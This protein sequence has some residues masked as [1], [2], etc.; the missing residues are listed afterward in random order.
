MIEDSSANKK[1]RAQI[2][3]LIDGRVILVLVTAF[4][5][6]IIPIIT[7]LLPD[8]NHQ[9]TGA[10]LAQGQTPTPT[11]PI[12]Y[13]MSGDPI[14]SASVAISMT[15]T[16]LPDGY[17]SATPV[18]RI[19]RYQTFR[20]GWM[21]E[22]SDPYDS[23]ATDVPVWIVGA[24]KPGITVGDTLNIPGE[25]YGTIVDNR[26]AEGAYVAWFANE[27]AVMSSGALISGGPNSYASLMA[28]QDEPVVITRPT[29]PSGHP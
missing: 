29:I 12:V 16:E 1:D 25:G 26:P 3:R 28:L 5:A 8:D 11:W 10:R 6:A 4:I 2:G 7:R 20:Q 13:Y 21:Q 23:I 22:P 15:L 24:Q 18:A 19:V 9:E 17:G 27:G 14:L